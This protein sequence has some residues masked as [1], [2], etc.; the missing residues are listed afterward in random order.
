MRVAGLV[1]YEF[2]IANRV[3]FDKEENVRQ[4][5]KEI[6]SEDLEMLDFSFKPDESR[7]WINRWVENITHNRI[8]DFATPDVIN[9]NTRMALVI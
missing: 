3:Y 7:N 8:K 2:E 1:T 9:S 5:M 4:C 6:L